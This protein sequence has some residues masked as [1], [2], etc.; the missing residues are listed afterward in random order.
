MKRIGLWH[1]TVCAL[2]LAL[3]VVGWSPASRAQP[4]PYPSKPIRLIVPFPPGGG[5]DLIGRFFADRL[6]QMLGQSVI[7]DNRGGAGGNIGNDMAAKAPADGYTLLLASGGMAIS[8]ALYRNLPY[9]CLTDYAPISILVTQSKVLVVN[10]SVPVRNVGE[11]IAFARN[12]EGKLSYGTPG[13]G[14]PQHM[15]MEMFNAMAKIDMV[16][17]PYR[18]TGPQLSGLLSGETVVT[19]ATLASAA[20]H[21][22]NG[23]MRAIGIASAQRS[24]LLPDVPTIAESGL[25]GYDLPDWYA[26]VAPARTPDAIVARLNAAIAAIE[27][28]P[29]AAAKLKSLGFEPHPSTPEALDALLRSESAK[30]EA[31]VRSRNLKVE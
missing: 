6:A 10:P 20:P 27:S 31:M 9:D 30:W 5:T 25:P 1:R 13:I 18:G 21:I 14:T 2:L 7:V 28:Q 3:G 29:E 16:Q 26:V 17:I 4:A 11:L 19:F 22:G 24:P 15:A 12:K 23:S 8:R